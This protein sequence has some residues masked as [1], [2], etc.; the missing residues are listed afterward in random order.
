MAKGQ[1]LRE[2]INEEYKWD[3]STIYKNID[4][5]NS[6]YDLTHKLIKDYSKYENTMMSSA[7]NLLDS[8]LDDIK[9]SRLINKLYMYAHLNS[10]SDTSNTDYQELKGKVSNLDIEYSKISSFVL[11]TLLK[12]DYSKI[13]KFYED[14]PKLLEHKFTFENT[15]RY[16]ETLLAKNFVFYLIYKIT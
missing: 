15:F 7:K 14:E 8:I 6:D 11:P 3:L 2:E 5:F 1:M 4:E 13:E 10:D 9:I 16:K 12:E